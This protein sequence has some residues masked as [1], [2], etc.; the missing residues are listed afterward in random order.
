MHLDDITQ[1][2]D[3]HPAIVILGNP[4]A[5]KTTTLQ[6][7]AFEAAQARLQGEHGLIPLFVRLSQQGRQD[8]YAFLEREWGRR[9]GQDFGESLASGRLLLLADGINEI[10]R[11]VR[12]ERLKAWRYFKDDYAGAN[13]MVFTGRTLDYES[14]LDLP[15]VQ[16]EPLDRERIVDYVQ[17]YKVEGLLTL[18]EDRHSPL[19]QMA[20]NP[21]NLALLAAAYQD[22]RHG[23]TNRGR[24]MEWF[25]GN[26]Y[27]RE[28]KL[29]HPGWL[30]TSLQ[31][32]VLG[33]LAFAM[34]RQGE[35]TTLPAANAGSGSH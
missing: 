34:Q 13:R 17:R 26:L 29:A 30:P 31:V 11:K 33:Q 10:P 32:H 3:T 8:P 23:M 35:S 21:F 6:K 5:G 15:R 18:L 2:L 20:R 12:A 25:V 14:L 22:N 24:L 28:E 1:A 7:L 4:G 9:T 16:V 19:R 27:S